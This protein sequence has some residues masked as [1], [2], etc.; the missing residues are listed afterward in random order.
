MYLDVFIIYTCRFK[1]VFRTKL[2]CPWMSLTL[3]KK[4]HGFEVVKFLIKF[5]ENF[6]AKL[7]NISSQNLCESVVVL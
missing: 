5:I 6:S 4:I 3:K 1:Q 7:G 2:E